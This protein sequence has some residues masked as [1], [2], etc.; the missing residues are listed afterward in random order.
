[1]PFKLMVS[2]WWL[3][4]HSNVK[5]LNGAEWLVGFY[6]CLKDEDIHPVDKEYLKEL[7]TWHREKKN[8]D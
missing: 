6:N 2:N 7:I 1:M 4:G 5:T 8:I 3:L